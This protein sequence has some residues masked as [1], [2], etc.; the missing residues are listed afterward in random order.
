MGKIKIVLSMSIYFSV[1]ILTGV[2]AILLNLLSVHIYMNKNDFLLGNWSIYIMSIVFAITAYLI[3]KGV[4][5]S[6]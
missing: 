3:G 6:K 2:F 4:M 1:C 5:Y